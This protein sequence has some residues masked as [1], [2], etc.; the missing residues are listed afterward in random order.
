MIIVDAYE[1]LT[2]LP[3]LGSDFGTPQVIRADVGKGGSIAISPNG[4]LFSTA[5]FDKIVTIGNVA[6][7]TLIRKI[8]T[9]EPMRAVRFSP[10]G[11]ILAASTKTNRFILLNLQT[12]EGRSYTVSKVDKNSDV[13]SIAFRSS[14]KWLATGH[15]DSSISL[16]NLDLY[17]EGHNFFVPNQSTWFVAFSPD[18]KVLATGQQGGDIHLW[19]VASG[20]LHGG[21]R[22]HT[23]GVRVLVFSPDGKTLASGGEDKN[24][25]IWR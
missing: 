14:G 22:G 10:S 25:L 18:S 24:I 19:D 2:F 15:M 9:P 13:G 3:I 12:G 16:W 8:E 11:Q 1:N 21:L 6:D 4:K 17:K 23:A 20:R 7:R 5:S